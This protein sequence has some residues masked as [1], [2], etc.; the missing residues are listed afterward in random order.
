MREPSE[1]G[2]GDR[3]RLLVHLL[4]HEVVV[5][6]LLRGLEVPVD[7]EGDR[8]HVFA[9]ERRD[10]KGAGTDLGDL[11]VLE[12]PERAGDAEKG[13]DVGCEQADPD[14]SPSAKAD[15]QGATRAALRRSSRAPKRTRPRSRTLRATCRG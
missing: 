13:G 3:T 4:A 7:V 10:P 9:F 5:T 6:R 14:D 8:L 11:V 12:R 15:D 1:Q 2:V